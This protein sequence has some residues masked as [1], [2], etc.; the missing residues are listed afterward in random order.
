MFPEVTILK[1]SSSLRISDNPIICHIIVLNFLY[2]SSRCLTCSNILQY[3][4]IRVKLQSFMAA[5]WHRGILST[6]C[7]TVAT[8]VTRNSGAAQ[9]WGRSFCALSIKR[10]MSIVTTLGRRLGERITSLF[11]GHAAAYVRICFYT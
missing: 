8:A 1:P 3:P 4:G 5:G 2:S 10:V 7:P 6:P 11:S 9:D